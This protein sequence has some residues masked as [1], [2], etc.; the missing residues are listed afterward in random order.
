MLADKLEPFFK[1]Y[2]ELDTL[3]SSADILSDISKM[4]TLSKEQKSLEPIILKAKE[5]LKILEQIEENKALLSD[6][7]LGELAKEELKNLE[8]IKLEFRA[9]GTKKAGAPRRAP[10]PFAFI[11]A[12]R[13]R[14]RV[15]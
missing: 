4:T 2:E 6:T 1:R 3:L 14:C 9:K 5:Y 11:R 12:A 13:A 8:E 7:E 10:L 15:R